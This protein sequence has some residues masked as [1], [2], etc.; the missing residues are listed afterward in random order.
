P[1]PGVSGQDLYYQLLPMEQVNAQGRLDSTLTI[2]VLAQAY[3]LS[4]VQV[5][6][7][8][9][10]GQRQ[11][12]SSATSFSHPVA[13]PPAPSVVPAKQAHGHDSKAGKGPKGDKH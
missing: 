6:V 1:R 9:A 4:S 2:P 12:A 11:L 13:A 3:S 5:H 7:F 10:T 8:D